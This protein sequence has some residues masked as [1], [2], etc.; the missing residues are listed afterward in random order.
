MRLCLCVALCGVAAS[1]VLGFERGHNPDSAY[2][3][4][5]LS[6]KIKEAVDNGIVITFDCK[7]KVNKSFAKINWASQTQ[8]HRFMLVHHSLSNRYLVHINNSETPKN[9]HTIGEATNF[10]M[11]TSLKFFSEYSIERS[12]TYMRLSLNKFKL[13]GPI[14]LN[15][16][17]AEHWNID[18]GWVPW[19]SEI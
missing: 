14:R 4:L 15:A 18:T 17:I 13:P 3:N 19:S 10:I 6:P 7:L 5:A 9:F 2:V 1:N 12:Q 8:A 16:F 11:E